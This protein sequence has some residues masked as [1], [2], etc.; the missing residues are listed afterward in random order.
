[1]LR[2]RLPAL[3]T[4]PATEPPRSADRLDLRRLLTQLFSPGNF[5]VGN[6][7]QATWRLGGI[8]TVPWEI[9]GGRLLDAR[10][11]RQERTFETWAIDAAAGP[12]LPAGPLIAARLDHESGRVF[13]TRAIY[14]YVW[15][16]YH[17]GDNVYLSREV[18]RW[19]HELVG[20]VDPA[21]TAE[22]TPFLCGRRREPPPPYLP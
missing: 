10:L 12:G 20:F 17:A 19:V 3:S 14:S 15:E 11:T 9:F 21:G 2:F 22:R 16:G 13:V 18:E 1:M 8:E 4:D 6:G 5:Y 7:L